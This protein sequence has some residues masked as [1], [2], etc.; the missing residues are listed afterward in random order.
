[1]AESR[2]ED[3]SATAE[4]NVTPR[5]IVQGGVFT[6]RQNMQDN[7]KEEY[8]RATKEAAKEGYAILMNGGT[9]IDAVEA[10]VRVL[11]SNENFN[12]GRG[13]FLNNEREVECSAMIME[14][15]NLK[16]GAVIAGKYF[17]HPVSLAKK[18]ML[19]SPHCA[20]SGDGALAFAR[21]KN[22]PIYD[23]NELIPQEAK[24]KLHVSY[25]NYLDYVKFRYLGQSIQD[26]PEDNEDTVSAVARD[27]NG[28]FACATS[29]GGI[30]G[31]W[32]G[33]VGDA[34][35]I[36]CG[37]YA[38]KDGSATCAGHGE[39]IMK[40]TLATQVI[41]NMKGGQSAEESAKSALE[42]MKNDVNGRGGIIAID[43]NGNYGKAF[44]DTLRM[45]WVSIEGDTLTYGIKKDESV[46]EPLDPVPR[47]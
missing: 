24:Q 44:S 7:I 20:L 47:G 2:A 25:E 8:I 33:R 9:A 6:S 28:I 38:N 27:T 23:P 37:G 5:I 4:G 45:V 32:K 17:L 19:E 15:G 16:T 11:E 26:H 21:E 35:L 43:R 22:F 30:A 14:G 41:Y 39:S 10:S 36:G 40:V 42:N 13:S 18:I 3:N 1:M 34:P 31:K 29:T 46:D 12:A